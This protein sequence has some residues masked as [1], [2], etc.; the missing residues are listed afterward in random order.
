MLKAVEEPSME[1]VIPAAKIVTVCV[2]LKMARKYLHLTSAKLIHN[3]ANMIQSS[4]YMPCYIT[5]LQYFQFIFNA[6]FSLYPR[7]RKVPVTE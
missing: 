4:I 6:I 7:F 3:V 5:Y 2:L 1:I